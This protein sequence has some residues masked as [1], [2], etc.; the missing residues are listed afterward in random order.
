M[1][2]LAELEVKSKQKNELVNI[3]TEVQ[4]AIHA[5]G[6]KE[7]ICVVFVPHTTASVTVNENSDPDVPRDINLALSAISPDRPEFRHDE[8]NSAAHTKTTLLGPST[9]LIISGGKLHLGVW[10]AIWFAEFDGPRTRK[11]LVRVLGE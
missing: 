7:G 1:T 11:V 5:S 9:T 2:Y 3:S 8:G 6:V 4:K 10:Q